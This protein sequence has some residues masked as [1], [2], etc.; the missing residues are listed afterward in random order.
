[1]DLL[2]V[3]PLGKSVQH[4]RP[5]VQ[6]PHNAVADRGVV[7]GEVAFGLAAFG[8]VDAVWTRES[9]R[10]LTNGQFDGF[11]GRR[12]RGRRRCHA[13]TV[14]RRVSAVAHITAG[15]RWTVAFDTC[16]SS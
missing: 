9:D 6:R 14:G 10:A 15:R 2:A 1:M 8:E 3:D 4:A 7:V 5:V 13:P 16:L 11:A 12:L